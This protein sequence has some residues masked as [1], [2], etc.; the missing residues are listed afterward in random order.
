[1]DQCEL[2]PPK[3]YKL[4]AAGGQAVRLEDRQLN[5]FRRLEKLKA[6][7]GSA[8]LVA[9]LGQAL[10]PT[11][12]AARTLGIGLPAAN[13][14]GTACLAVLA[15]AAFSLAFRWVDVTEAELAQGVL[16]ARR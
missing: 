4:R 8:G 2:S 5:T 15:L 14:I 3:G 13:Q 10:W 7:L 6:G 12:L 16:S 1:M 11:D 9:V